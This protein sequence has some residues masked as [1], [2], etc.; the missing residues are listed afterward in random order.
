MQDD[1]HAD[2]GNQR[3]QAKAAAQRPVGEALDRP[4]VERGQRHG[5]QEH[6]EQRQRHRGHAD[7]DQREKA[8]QRDEAPNHEDVAMGE[9]DHADDAVDHRVADGDQAVDRA[10]RDAVDELLEKI[11]HRPLSA[12]VKVAGTQRLVRFFVLSRG[13][14]AGQRWPCRRLCFCPAFGL[15]LRPWS[16]RSRSRCASALRWRC[17]QSWRPGS[18]WR[19]AA[20]CRSGAPRAGR[21]TSASSWSMRC[22]CGFWFPRQRWAPRFMPPATASACFIG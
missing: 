7:C 5:D 18:C 13:V 4:A 8:D 6:Q 12:R 21:R 20:G 10:E 3:R 14:P 11:F 9:V 22:W 17:S 1:R 16:L 19:R 15:L 2:R